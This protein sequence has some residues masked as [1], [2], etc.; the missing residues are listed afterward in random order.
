M[1]NPK[2]DYLE[3]LLSSKT[4]V[5]MDEISKFNIKDSGLYILQPCFD[6]EKITGESYLKVGMTIG[7]TGL[8]GRLSTHFSNHLRLCDGKLK[9]PTVLSRHM[10]LDRT[11]SKELG[12]DFTIHSD[13]KKFLKELCY[14]QVLPLKE[15]NWASAEEKRIKRRELMK[16]ESSQ[17]ENKVRSKTRYIDDVIER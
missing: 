15:F 12:L 10:Y 16:I 6:L 3:Q 8:R 17:I 5:F 11:L 1:I 9:S 2:K 4:T 13:R 7:K 14:F